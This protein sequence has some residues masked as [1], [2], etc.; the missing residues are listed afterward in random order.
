[1]PD[2][3]ASPLTELLMEAQ[4]PLTIHEFAIRGSWATE[5][6]QLQWGYTA[7]VFVNG[8]NW[9]RADNPCNPGAPSPCPAVGTTAQFGTTSLPPDN[10]AH[11]FNIAGGINLPMRTRVNASFTYQLGLQ[12]QDFQQQTYSNSLV[13]TNSRLVL[14]QGS[15]NGNVQSF[16]FNLDATSRPLPAP[17]TFSFRYRLYDMMDNSDTP[18]FSAFIINDQNTIASGPLKAGRFDFQRQNANLDGRWQ[19]V[20]S[21]A[22][23][24]GVGWE[25]WNRNRNWEVTHTDEATAKAALDYTPYD[26]LLVRASYQPSFRRGNAYNTN[27]YLKNNADDPPGFPGAQNFELRK[28]NEADRNRQRV[29]LLVQVTP[30]DRL[31]F[32][33]A[34]GYKLDDYI[35][36]GMHQNGNTR[37]QVTMET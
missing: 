4:P 9:V 33:P 1:M 22:L 31:T 28:F 36:S 7:S 10:Q 37:N 13:L 34:A 5:M 14:P 21:T 11:T 27:A 35:A 24:L 25:G 16:L 2:L 23:T 19:I 30:T 8:F 12:N 6:I 29:D 32:T 15:L 17:V 3:P 20:P 18:T 26:W